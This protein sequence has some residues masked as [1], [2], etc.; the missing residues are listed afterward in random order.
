MCNITFEIGKLGIFSEAFDNL[1]RV[2][3]TITH[4]F[5]EEWEI[6]YEIQ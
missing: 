2:I 6:T 4:W 1:A 5:L 3:L